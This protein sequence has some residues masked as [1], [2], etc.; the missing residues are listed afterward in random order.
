MS[1]VTKRANHS[2]AF[3]ANAIA[4][5]LGALAFQFL[6]AFGVDL[7]TLMA[8][9]DKVIAANDVNVMMLAITAAVQIRANVSFV[10]RDFGGV[11]EKYPELIIEGERPNLDI[12]N[13]GALHAL[14]HIFCILSGSSHGQKALA[15]AGNCITGENCPE[16]EAGKI[17]AEIARSWTPEDRAAFLA[18]QNKRPEQVVAVFASITGAKAEFVNQMAPGTASGAAGPRVPGKRPV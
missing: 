5:P 8:I 7:Q 9:A 13:F 18:W 4:N 17:N 14:G 2:E 10:G 11:R 6:A 16:S 3:R 12:Y 1:K 15:K